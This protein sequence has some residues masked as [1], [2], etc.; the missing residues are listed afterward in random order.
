MTWLAGGLFVFSL[1]LLAGTVRIFRRSQRMVMEERINSRYRSLNERFSAAIGRPAHRLRTDPLHTY[2]LRAGIALTPAR[3]GIALG[4][5]ALAVA[6][7]ALKA[8]ALGAVSVLV[9]L[10]LGAVLWPQVQ[11]RKRMEIMS[12]QIPLFLDQVVRALTTGRGMDSALQMVSLETRPP[13]GEVMARV[14]H[15][16]SLGEDMGDALRDTARIHGLRELHLVAMAVQI[17]RGYG[18]SPKEMLESISKLVR[19]REQAQR[20]LA[21]LTGETRLSAWLLSLLPTAMALYMVAVNP[22]YINSMW[23]DPTGRIVLLMALGL[24]AAGA[25]ILWRMVKSI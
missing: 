10:L 1:L 16:T 13:L 14:H 8:G 23:H 22:N 25:F 9:A 3:V 20:E 18:S 5:A 15:V 12:A 2:L 11:Y 7:V 19:H 17:A 4:G 21:A 6:L 24:Q